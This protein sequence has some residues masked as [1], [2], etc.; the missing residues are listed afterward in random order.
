MSV[1][2]SE[3]QLRDLIADNDDGIDKSCLS[4]KINESNKAEV[5]ALRYGI[6][7]SLQDN[8]V[9]KRHLHLQNMIEGVI[10]LYPAK[11]TNSTLPSQKAPEKY[12]PKSTSSPRRHG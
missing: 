11:M 9:W 4:I 1:K 3:T 10:L 7:D 5:Q 2:L 6:D 8:P 12:L